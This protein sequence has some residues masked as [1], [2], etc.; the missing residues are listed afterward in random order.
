MKIL[1]SSFIQRNFYFVSESE[2]QFPP[3]K[4][5]PAE[6]HESPQFSRPLFLPQFNLC[7]TKQQLPKLSSFS[8]LLNSM[9]HDATSR[10]TE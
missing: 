10:C 7:A 4:L 9:K 3:Y 5:V 1:T 2:H 8:A 6:K